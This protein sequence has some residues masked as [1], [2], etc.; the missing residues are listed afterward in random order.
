MKLIEKETLSWVELD[1]FADVGGV[2]H[3]I[4]TRCGGVS[5]E[6]YA[7]LNMS[8]YRDDDPAAVA[9]NQARGYGVFGRSAD[10]LVHAHLQ[11]GKRVVRVGSAEHGAVIPACDG[12]ISNEIGCGLTMNFADC[13]SVFLYDPVHHAIGLGHAGWR[14]AI[15]NLPG[16]LVQAMV[17]AFGSDPQ[18]LIAGLGPCI[19][20]SF[21]EVD[22]PVI[23]EVR[24]VF[25][26][27]VD[28]LLSYRTDDDGER[29]GRPYFNLALANHIG[30]YEADVKNVALPTFCTAART[31]LFFSHRAEKGQTGRF[32]AVLALDPK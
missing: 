6:P 15:A 20:A 16:A 27:W 13:G 5:A 22:E 12:L 29:I 10:R 1:R 17:A 7:S 9:E 14:G 25:P 24:R 3:G 31:D 18:Q 11:H 19:S 23:S 21:Y 2:T 32:A 8:S 26:K 30:L 4:L 28:R